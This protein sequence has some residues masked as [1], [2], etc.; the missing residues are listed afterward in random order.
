MRAG[1]PASDVWGGGP[2]GESGAVGGV[3]A[4]SLVDAPAGSPAPPAAVRAAGEGA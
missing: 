4:G 2:V 3:K 1:L